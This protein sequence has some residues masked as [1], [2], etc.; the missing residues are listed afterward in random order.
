MWASPG[1]THCPPTGGR[2]IIAAMSRGRP[3]TY[4]PELADEICRRLAGGATL[5]SICRDAGMPDAS[6]VLAWAREMEGFSQ[7]Y[8]RSREIGY[9]VM[10][11]EI[12]ELADDRAEDPQRSRLQ[13]DARK[14]LLA[15]ALPKIYG[16]GQ[17]R[18]V[19]VNVGGQVDHRHV[20]ISPGLAARLREIGGARAAELF[21]PEDEGGPAEGE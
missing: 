20:H 3:S 12:L 10:A 14:W 17:Q 21:P 19:D 8:A 6:T 15:K 5:R 7:Q 11:D 18:R 4:T 2:A 13:V 9:Q 16:D 1:P